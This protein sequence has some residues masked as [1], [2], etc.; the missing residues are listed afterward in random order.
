M[1]SK[2][3]TP[4][5]EVVQASIH[6]TDEYKCPTCGK[7]HRR[8]APGWKPGDV[9]EGRVNSQGEI[10]DQSLFDY[11]LGVSVI[12]G[13][14][15]VIVTQ[16]IEHSPSRNLHSIGGDASKSYYLVAGKAIITDVNG[17]PTPNTTEFLKALA[18]S[19]HRA[20]LTLTSLR[21]KIIEKYWADLGN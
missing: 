5:P 10:L 9:N 1:I 14:N 19:P 17:K 2:A 8:W 18:E 4:P 13:P 16:S 3:A 11:R 7:M 12:D 20:E 6:Y 15:G 21:G